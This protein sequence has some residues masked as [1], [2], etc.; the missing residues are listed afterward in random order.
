MTKAKVGDRIRIVA[1]MNNSMSYKKWR[2]RAG[3]LVWRC[4]GSSN[5]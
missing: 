5:L 1:A 4:S 2:G 3:L